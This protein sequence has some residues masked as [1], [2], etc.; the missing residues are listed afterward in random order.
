M[1]SIPILEEIHTRE[2]TREREDYLRRY[3]F[4]VSREGA[5]CAHGQ[6]CLQGKPLPIDGEVVMTVY[7]T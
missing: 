4:T 3:R 2:R 7:N 1:C 6:L 5:S